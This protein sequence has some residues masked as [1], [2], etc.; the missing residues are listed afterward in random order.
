MQG[1]D[2]FAAFAATYGSL[3]DAEQDYETIK[4]LY[5]SEGI[6][7]TFD[8]AIIAKDEK[9]KVKIVKRHEQPTRQG[10]WLGGGLGLATGLCVALFPAV[11][12]GAAVVYGTG[13]GA[14]LGAIA[15]HAAGGMSRSDLKD[16][17]E[18][19]DE[20]ECALVAVAATAIADRVAASIERAEKV[21][22]KELKADAKALKEDVETATAAQPTVPSQR[23]EAT[24]PE[25]VET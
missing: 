19:L 12:I 9:G 8:A 16:L 7:D 5:Y 22:R 15:G 10:A 14:G 3:E 11:G 4:S 23:E 20:G 24:S 6:L 18:T 1:L 13:L 17:G 2:T 25:H 21:E